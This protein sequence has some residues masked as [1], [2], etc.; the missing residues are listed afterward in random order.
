MVAA[1]RALA[2]PPT[3][4]DTFGVSSATWKA[5]SEGSENMPELSVSA[6]FFIVD[7]DQNNIKSAFHCMGFKL[8]RCTHIM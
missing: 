1:S 7:G 2:R 6:C 8:I 3:V 5:E 4:V